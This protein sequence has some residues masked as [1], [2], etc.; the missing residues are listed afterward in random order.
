MVVKLRLISFVDLRKPSDN[1]GNDENSEN[2]EEIELEYEENDGFE[3]LFFLILSLNPQLLSSEDTDAINPI[4]I[5]GF[6][7]EI[8]NEEDLLLLSSSNA[9]INCDH[10]RISCLIP[11][12]REI[13]WEFCTSLIPKNTEEQ[14]LLQ[15]KFDFIDNS[16]TLCQSCAKLLDPSLLAATSESSLTSGGHA[17]PTFKCQ[18]SRLVE[19][20]LLPPLPVAPTRLVS[21]AGQIDSPLHLFLKKS[22]FFQALDDQKR[23]ISRLGNNRQLIEQR[24]HFLDRLRSGA[25]V[26]HSYENPQHQA[27]ALAQ[28]DYAKILEYLVEET[29]KNEEESEVTQRKCAEELFFISLLRWFKVDFFKW[30]NKPACD[31]CAVRP[32]HMEAIGMTQASV[33]EKD[34]G[35]ASRVELYRC[36]HC[37]QTTRFPR[38]NNPSYMM[39]CS[40]RGRCGEFAN[41]FGLV[42]RALGF[43]V[44][45]VMDWTDHVWIEVWIESYQSFVHMDC[46]ER[47]FNGPLMYEVG[48]RKRL[49]HVVSFNRRFVHDCSSRYSRD[50][51]QVIQRRN[52]E[53]LPETEAQTII[54]QK[55]QEIK[56]LFSRLSL[57]FP[58][59]P[60]S[61]PAPL[62]DRL[63][64]GAIGFQ[65]FPLAL[66]EKEMHYREAKDLYDL[67]QLQFFSKKTEKLEELRGR[68]SG[69]LAWRI[70]RGEIHGVP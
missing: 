54:S 46:C 7:S 34:L 58:S 10:V 70:Q 63:A 5:D 13:Y 67:K 18:S 57:T 25:Q 50:L 42:C 16:V 69:D 47:S 31:H 28:I 36:Q 51:E 41:V 44:N 8:R 66:S 26:V 59:P 45:Y 21:L 68:I 65:Q 4:I 27:R 37:S 17:L 48:W 15:C 61:T 33:P 64:F 38:Y 11:P 20:G 32:H 29:Q 2:F 9:R 43:D 14:E 19:A 30:C 52:F 39:E 6:G 53:V 49:T 1:L 60:S 55:N 24:Q 23:I 3:T 62:V 35:W 12:S 56:Q 40:R 22:F